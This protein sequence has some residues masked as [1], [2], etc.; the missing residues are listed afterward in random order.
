MLQPVQCIVWNFTGPCWPLQ[1][2]RA[3]RLKSPQSVNFM[4][5]ARAWSDIGTR[6]PSGLGVRHLKW[7]KDCPSA[8][9]EG[10]DPSLKSICELSVGPLLRF[11]PSITPQSLKHM[12][13]I[14]PKVGKISPCSKKTRQQ[15]NSRVSTSIIRKE[16]WH[17]KSHSLWR[18][19]LL[20]VRSVDH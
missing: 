12:T 1:R 8:A 13:E 11:R 9:F 17:N 6:R 2:S 18:P 14:R 20:V 5:A 19:C 4:G 10:F 7:C 16:W 15:N 3:L